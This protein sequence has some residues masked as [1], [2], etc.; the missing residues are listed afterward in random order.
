MNSHFADYS[1]ISTLVESHQVDHAIV[2]FTKDGTILF[3]SDSYSV[4]H[5]LSGKTQTNF[6]HCF[7]DYFH[8]F[9]RKAIVDLFDSVH[10]NFHEFSVELH[11]DS[12]I[13]AEPILSNLKIEIIDEDHIGTLVM[14]LFVKDTKEQLFF[15]NSLPSTHGSPHFKKKQ[16]LNIDDVDFFHTITQAT[17]IL[18]DNAPG[19][20]AITTSLLIVQKVLKANA[21]YI[22]QIMGERDSPLMVPRYECKNNNVTKWYDDANSMLFHD[23]GL[24]RW[25]NVLSRKG[26]IIG[27]IIDFSPD[28]A[29]VLESIGLKSVLILPVFVRSELWGFVEFDY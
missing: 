13:L 25:Y 2:R 3:V 5:Y 17:T 10:N 21:M 7:Y 26:V 6:L 18:A 19:E 1:N 23:L 22:T 12:V 15:S 11:F 8:D 24:I 16:S 27:N 20:D 4:Y 14:P 29:Q 9:T 28:E